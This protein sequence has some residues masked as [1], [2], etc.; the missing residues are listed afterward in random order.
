M[1][2]SPTTPVLEG[3][4]YCPCS[5]ADPCVWRK[6]ALE[7]NITYSTPVL[8][9]LAEDFAVDLYFKPAVLAKVDPTSE[10]LVSMIHAWNSGTD[11]NE[12]TMRVVLFDFKE[13]FDLIDP[14][15]S[16]SC[17]YMTSLTL[18]SLGSSISS[19]RAN[20]ELNLAMT[21]SQNGVLP[22]RG[23]PKAQ[24]W[25]YGCS[26]SWSTGLMFLPP[27]SGNTSTIPP[28][29]RISKKQ[30]SHIQAAVDNLVNRASADKFQL[31]VYYY[32]LYSL[33][34]FSL[35]KSL[36]LILE[37]SANYRLVSYLLADN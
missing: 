9:K 28:S 30:D 36:Q 19:L 12:A 21:A 24:N 23:F 26:S 33:S 14:G 10:A 1:L 32:T 8:S 37:I 6:Q 16:R 22:R 34:V 17:A 15:R 4:R 25:G 27:I 2:G 3:S 13:A 7:I 31:N 11:G 5:Q 18:L 29:R 20:S 35:G